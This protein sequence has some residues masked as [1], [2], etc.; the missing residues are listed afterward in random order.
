MDARKLYVAA[1]YASM[2]RY[3]ELLAAAAN[4]TRGE[5]ECLLAERFPR[6]DAPALVRPI[7]S[8][9]RAVGACVFEQR[10]PEPVPSC[11]RG[12]AIPMGPLA[13]YATLVWVVTYQ[14]R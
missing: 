13:P 1:G 3:A 8:P 6:P 9:A 7:A 5:I 11:E 2:Y 12:L 10:V 4:K 14:R